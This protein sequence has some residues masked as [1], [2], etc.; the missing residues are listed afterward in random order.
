MIRRQLCAAVIL[1][2]CCGLAQAAGLPLRLSEQLQKPAVS[3]S[4]VASVSRAAPLRLQ[5]SD[6]ASASLVNDIVLDKAMA[7]LG[8]QYEFGGNNAGTVDCSALVQQI[9]GSAGMALPRTTRE[10]LKVGESVR[11]TP[12][13]AGD[14]LLYRW[15]R[16]QLHVAVYLDDG[17]IVHASPSVGRVIV[18]ELDAQWRRHLVAIRRL[19]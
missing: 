13:R 9:F 17:H 6:D 15:R 12:L 8:T 3:S 19:L 1:L 16:H 18:T 7:M 2:P 14:L 11:N 5:L 10:L 4:V